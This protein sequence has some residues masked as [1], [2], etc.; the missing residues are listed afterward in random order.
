MTKESSILNENGDVTTTFSPMVNEEDEK[1]VENGHQNG[2]C[3]TDKEDVDHNNVQIEQSGST[4]IYRLHRFEPQR[5]FKIE[6]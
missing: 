6:L 4:L 1:P 5:A 2:K 3:H